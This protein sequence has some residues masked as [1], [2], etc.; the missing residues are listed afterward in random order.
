MRFID[1]LGN[2]IILADYPKRIISL[3]PSQTELLHYFEL[4]GKVIGI[5]RFCIYPEEWFKNKSRVGGTKNLHLDKIRELNPDILIGNKEENEKQQIK[6][7]MKEFPVWMSDICTLENAMEMIL[8]VGELTGVPEKAVTLSKQ[9]QDSFDNLI[10]IKKQKRVAYL[11][12][13]RPYMAAAG[14]TFIDDMLQRC[15][16]INVFNNYQRYPKISENDLIT[17]KPEII[18]LSSEP[19]PF[20]EKHISE[21]W[22]ILP[23]SKIHLIDGELFSWYGSRL[24][25]APQYFLKLINMISILE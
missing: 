17:N 21:I 10:P 8:A 13:R 24:L 25:H 12:W 22:S 23:K 20:K 7:L 18:F 2:E 16:L 11:I 5:T 14:G 15:G 6:E 19:Y 9:I 1:Q 3:V 4:D